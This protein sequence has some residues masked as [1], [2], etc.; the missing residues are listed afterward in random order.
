MIKIPYGNGELEIGE[1]GAPV[2]RSR[3]DEKKTQRRGEDLVR[4]AMDDPSGGER[5]CIR[6]RGKKSCCILVS[7]PEGPVPSG[8][9]LPNLVRE[10]KEGNPSM[11][12]T[13]LVS[14]SEDRQ[15]AEEKLKEKVDAETLEVCRIVF[16]DPA[17]GESHTQI[18]MLP[19]GAPLSVDKTALD[20]DLLV[21]EGIVEPHCFYGF[22]GG[23]QSVLPGI[24]GQETLQGAD[25]DKFLKSPAVRAGTLD[26]NPIH[27][28]MIAA[29]FRVKLSYIV[30]TVADEDN[31]TVQAFA[32]NYLTAHRAACEFLTEWAAAEPV[33]SQIV[34]TSVKGSSGQTM[35]HVIGALRSAEAAALEGATLIL[36]AQTLGNLTGSWEERMLQEILKEHTVLAVTEPEYKETVEKLGMQFASSLEEAL[37]TAK[38]K[39]GESL[40]VVPNGSAVILT[41]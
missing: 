19:S 22:T 11:D 41:K 37:E 40:A 7:P 3:I 1:Q 24:C 10:L 4:E 15:T 12:I 32:G 34:V 38:Q 5:L 33:P 23:G 28:D 25:L 29:C 6:A 14:S 36:C 20:T 26:D 8:Q 27:T 30:N 31:H 18:G 21:A 17:D 9:I 16:H 35:E 39:G 13:L 2:L